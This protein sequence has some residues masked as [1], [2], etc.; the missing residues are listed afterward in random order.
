MQYPERLLRL[1]TNL[2]EANYVDEANTIAQVLELQN[3]RDIQVIP[4]NHPLHERLVQVLRP[5]T[6]IKDKLQN[7]SQRLRVE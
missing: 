1:I 5:Q 7:L 3:I 6:L 2:A 4:I